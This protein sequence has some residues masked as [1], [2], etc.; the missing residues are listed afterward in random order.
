MLVQAT[1]FKLVVVNLFA[2]AHIRASVNAS[3]FIVHQFY[4]NTGRVGQRSQ[5]RESKTIISCCQISLYY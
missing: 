4:V 5:Q 1:S 2:I 3:V